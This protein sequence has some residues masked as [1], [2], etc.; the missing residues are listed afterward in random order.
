T[1]GGNSI[2]QLAFLSPGTSNLTDPNLDSDRDGMPD[3][4]ETDHGLN[5]GDPSD[6]ALD[7]D[8]D[9]QTNLFE[10]LGGTDPRDRTSFLA[11]DSMASDATGFALRFTARAGLRYTVEFS[12]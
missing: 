6:A 12:D 8:R 5:P 4:W 7:H 9:L 2:G 10:Y 1:D 3:S 11:I